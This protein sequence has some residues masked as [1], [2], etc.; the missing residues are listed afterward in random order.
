MFFLSLKNINKEGKNTFSFLKYNNSNFWHV[1]PNRSIYP[2]VRNE[3]PHFEESGV[4]VEEPLI[5][6]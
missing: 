4:G 1:K 6:I 2:M 3:N 5:Y